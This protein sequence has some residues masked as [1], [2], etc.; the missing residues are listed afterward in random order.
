MNIITETNYYWVIKF[1]GDNLE[2]IKK[3]LAINNHF[4]DC[5]IG[6]ARSGKTGLI[7]KCIHIQSDATH[8]CDDAFHYWETV[9][10][11]NYVVFDFEDIWESTKEKLDSNESYSIDWDKK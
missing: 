3:R 1:T 9:F 11:G 8:T 4:E 5:E 10:I 2:E 7:T 6:T